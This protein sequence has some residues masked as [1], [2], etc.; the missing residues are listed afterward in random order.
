MHHL[1][2]APCQE[3]CATQGSQ[4][5][6]AL[7]QALIARH[8]ERLPERSGLSRRALP[9]RRR[10][11][12][13]MLPERLLHDAVIQPDL[14]EGFA[15]AAVPEAFVKDGGAAMQRDPLD[16]AES[17]A[18]SRRTSCVPK[19]WPCMAAWTAIWK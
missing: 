11:A 8:R 2:D 1:P 5:S 7:A 16:G 19:P 3:Q 15:D 17:S 18:S 10:P 13:D 4:A 12:Q 9:T 6:V 14:D